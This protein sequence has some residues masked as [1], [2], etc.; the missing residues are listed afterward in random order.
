MKVQ[1]TQHSLQAGEFWVKAVY[2]IHFMI[3][4]WCTALPELIVTLP[5]I[6]LALP[7][8]ISAVQERSA[9]ILGVKNA[10]TTIVFIW[11]LNIPVDT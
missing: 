10:E 4:E 7:N 2:R 1:L 8:C 11:R 6:S 5:I 9:A 3:E